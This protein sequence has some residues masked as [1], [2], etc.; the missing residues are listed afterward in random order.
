[1]RPNDGVCF[2]PLNTE[3]NPVSHLPVLLGAHHILHVSRIRAKTK[4]NSVAL[5]RTRTIPTERPPPVGEVSANFCGQTGV[6]WSAQRVPTAVNLCFLDLE[7][8][9]FSF[10]QLLNS[11][12]EAHEAEWTPFQTHYYSENLVP[13]E[14]EP[15]TSVSVDR[16]SD[17][18][19]TEA[20]RIR[21]KVSE[22]AT[23]C[24]F[25]YCPGM[26]TTKQ[27]HELTTY[28]HDILTTTSRS[29]GINS[30]LCFS[31]FIIFFAVCSNQKQ[32]ER[33]QLKF[34][35]HRKVNFLFVEYL[36]DK[37]RNR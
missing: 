23:I 37:K 31:H 5:V 14:I 3:L 17:H 6:T 32:W 7:P 9:L 19:T 1:M 27:S 33:K 24:R 11:P 34:S 30:L 13:P 20:V 36:C 22:T 25:R 28:K 29:E 18:Q 4:I 35:R 2:N 16:N 10:K 8:L 26:Y 12:H 21:A 15:E